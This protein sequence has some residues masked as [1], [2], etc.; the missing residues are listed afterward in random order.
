VSFARS[1]HT[2]IRHMASPVQ[3]LFLVL[4]QKTHPVLWNLDSTPSCSRNSNNG[5][6]RR[7]QQGA[8][9]LLLTSARA[10]RLLLTLARA[11]CLLLMS[12]RSHCL[13]LTSLQAHC[14]P[15]LQTH[16]F[17]C[18]LFFRLLLLAFHSELYFSFVFDV[19]YIYG[20]V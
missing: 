20:F 1:Q 19:E 14:L 18:F 11:H 15:L 12:V 4:I 8:H 9:C 6:A 3:P 7:R 5:N 13:L 2:K 17:L 16:S 10:H